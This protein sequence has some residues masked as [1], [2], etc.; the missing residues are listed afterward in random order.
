MSLNFHHWT[1]SIFLISWRIYWLLLMK[2]HL[3]VL[4]MSWL[5]FVLPREMSL[6]CSSCTGFSSFKSWEHVQLARLS[7]FGRRFRLQDMRRHASPGRTIAQHSGRRARQQIRRLCRSWRPGTKQT[8]SWLSVL[9]TYLS[10]WDWVSSAWYCHGFTVMS[11][12]K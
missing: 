5:G 8:R 7:G 2:L 1:G 4:I 11:L 6:L 12:R 3:H 9:C 10:V